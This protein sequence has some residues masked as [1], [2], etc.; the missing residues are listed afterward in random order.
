MLHNNYKTNIIFLSVS[1]IS[2]IILS[3]IIASFYYLYL[4]ESNIYVSEIFSTQALYL[5]KNMMLANIPQAIMNFLTIVTSSL[6]AGYAFTTIIFAG[7][8]L[9]V[10]ARLV[11]EVK[12]EKNI[13]DQINFVKLKERQLSK[14]IIQE[15]QLKE[16]QINK[17]IDQSTDCYVRLASDYRILHVNTSAK[18]YF[19]KV[20]SV[21]AL[22]NSYL[23]DLM[24]DIKS[25]NFVQV[26]D[27]V[28]KTQ[29]S[30][31]AEIYLQQ[32]KRWMLIRLYY[33]SGQIGVYFN[34]ITAKKESSIGVESGVS[35]LKQLLDTSIDS[36]ALVDLNWKY[37]L[38]NQKWVRSFGLEDKQ[39]QGRTVIDSIPSFAK[40]LAPVQRD[41]VRGDII[42]IPEFETI[43]LGKEEWLRFEVRPYRN[44]DDKISG[45]IIS[46]VFT[47][48]ARKR[49][50]QAERQRQTERKLA[51][52]DM[53]TGLPNRQLF[54]DRLSEALTNSYRNLKKT[55]L[56]F[57]DLD[58][59]KAVNDT[60]GH[61]VGD[62]LLQDVSQRLQ[63]HTRASDTVA[64][65]GGDEFTV[66]LTNIDEVQDVATVAGKII[67]VIGEPYDY[68][69]G[70]V[71]RVTAS[72]GISMYPKDGSN[73]V[74]LIR[75]A[76]ESMYKA[77]NG[78]KNN[79]VFY[80]SQGFEV[81]AE[82]IKAE[83]I[84][85]ALNQNELLLHYQGYFD[86][87]KQ[88]VYGVEALLRWN[89]P[90]Y[91]LLRAGQFLAAIEQNDIMVEIG[92]FA[93][94]K[95]CQ[96]L[97]DWEKEGQTGLLLTLNVSPR[98]FLDKT[99]V[100]RISKLIAEYDIKPNSLG[101][102]ISEK[103]MLQNNDTV[104]KTL[105]DLK[106]LGIVLVV[107]NLDKEGLTME[108][109]KDNPIDML[110]IDYKYIS[111]IGKKK[112]SEEM[113]KTFIDMARKLG[114]EPAA[115]C[116]ETPEQEKF[117]TKHGCFKMQGY[118]FGRPSKPTKHFVVNA[119]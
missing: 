52:H 104:V 57:I 61:D 103:I 84:Q 16:V 90:Q 113:I 72:I 83:D 65:M 53:L 118:L 100:K 73:S 39:I 49:R 74:D 19:S 66:I 77:K 42:K 85:N 4:Y 14:K 58:G 10:L 20:T 28:L 1:S 3:C 40:Q 81:S 92:Q 119:K 35:L 2:W 12:N 69:D 22:N 59:F 36:V 17:V 109:L 34:D 88:R 95:A 78:G 97:Q 54:H 76:D 23:P 99:F 110:K 13:R 18:T 56:L 106:A 5:E 27:S 75:H 24:P 82:N 44:E 25:T 9:I 50:K 62:R 71:A 45:F 86:C 114:M 30:K 89:H 112:D 68:G 11:K 51:Y 111:E 6:L 102:E 8:S 91:G 43:L 67:K 33:E 70:I 37:L 48:Q 87:E 31:T 108:M 55:G 64:R 79:Y 47:T 93:L 29:V 15:R 117:L 26:F 94:R 21:S 115:D 7:F 98:E 107:E 41:L 116:V 38:T 32:Q 63:E 60:L 96:Q 46:A 80:E 101:F 105:R